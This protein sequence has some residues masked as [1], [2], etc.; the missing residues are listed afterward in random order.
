MKNN[1]QHMSV[2]RALQAWV[3]FKSIRSVYT[4][5]SHPYYLTVLEREAIL[6]KCVDEF[7][8]LIDFIK[9]KK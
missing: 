3:N 6:D 9:R 7:N 5:E 4:K 2:D 1:I 8:D